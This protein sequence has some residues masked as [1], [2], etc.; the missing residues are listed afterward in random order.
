MLSGTKE[1]NR[2]GLF[3]FGWTDKASMRQGQVNTVPKTK[4]SGLADEE[5]DK[6]VIIIPGRGKRSAKVL[7]YE[8][9]W[10]LENVKAGPVSNK[11]GNA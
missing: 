8:R 5:G 9:T 6:V 3:Q 4:G 1:K 2:E 7:G 11:K 10:H